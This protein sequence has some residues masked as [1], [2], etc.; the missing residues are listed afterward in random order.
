[1]S[2][3]YNSDIGAD[4]YELCERLLPILGIMKYEMPTIVPT[5]SNVGNQ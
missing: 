4:A 3:A 2:D 1:V 5:T